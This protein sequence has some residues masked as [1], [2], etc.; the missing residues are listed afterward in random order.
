[1]RD[2]DEEALA[3]LRLFP[4]ADDFNWWDYAAC[5][6]VDTEEFYPEKGGCSVIARR[7]CAGCM[8][9]VECLDYALVHNERGTW[10]GLSE[11]ARLS[12]R[13]RWAV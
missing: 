5:R 10:G 9:R 3:L 1:M 12:L 7:I 13:M 2:L 4:L 8:V 6:G 11:N